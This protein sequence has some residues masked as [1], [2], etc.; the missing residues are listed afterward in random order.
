MLQNVSRTKSR[1]IYDFKIKIINLSKYKFNNMINVILYFKII[2][3]TVQL[4]IIIKVQNSG[5]YSNN[6]IKN[7]I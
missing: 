3:C 1:I 4:I 7:K 6:L 5:E 2:T